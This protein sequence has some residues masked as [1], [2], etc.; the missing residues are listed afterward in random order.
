MRRPGLRLWLVLCVVALVAGVLWIAISVL[1]PMP[2]RSLTM[3][4][5]PAG[6]AYGVFGER[7]RAILAREGVHL[8]LVPTNGSYDNAARL[9]DPSSGVSVAF[10]QAGTTTAEESPDLQSLG[11]VFYEPLWL[12]CRCT[13]GGLAFH[14]GLGTHLS[15]GPPGSASRAIALR[16]MQL[17]G[18][19]PA[20]LRLEGY[21]PEQAAESL[22]RGELDSVIMSTSW[23]SPAVQR[24]LGDPSIGL[25]GFPRADAYIALL[26]F[27]SKVVLPMGVANLAQNRPPEDVVLLAPK[28]ALV[29][30]RDLHP[31]LQ[32]LLIDAAQK[33][34]S[35]PGIFNAAGTFPAAEAIDLPLSDEARQMY[36]SGPGFLRRNLPFWLAELVQRMLL[37]AIPV[38]GL[39]YPLARILPSGWRWQRERRIYR[40]YREL[41]RI[42]VELRRMPS[43]SRRAELL[44]HLDDLAQRAAQLRLPDSFSGMCYDLKN[45]IQFVS[46]RV[47]GAAPRV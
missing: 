10:V 7:Y 1:R 28:A 31:A 26:P 3:A 35:G 29:V 9:R 20:R 2:E 16:L 19:D 41:G 13:P 39:I 25:A 33:I 36:K 21:S 27:L 5:G 4:T 30:R 17:N 42:E 45:N 38:L 12:F 37:L 34:H 23:D 40:M 24:L 47:A 14:Q 22:L 6:G 11:S 44:A 8:H 46:D 18:L 43:D 15:I 32:Y